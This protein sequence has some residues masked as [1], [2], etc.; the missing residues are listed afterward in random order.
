MSVIKISDLPVIQTVN[1]A[2][3]LPVVD[4]GLNRKMSVAQLT[5]FISGSLTVP[6]AAIENIVVQLFP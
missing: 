4:A 5:S 6:R 3:V 1:T 2:T